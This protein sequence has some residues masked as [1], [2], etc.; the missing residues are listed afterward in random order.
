LLLV[1]A[2]QTA[3]LL[4]IDEIIIDKTSVR[5]M[6]KEE[7]LL[8][9]HNGDNSFL[10]FDEI[11]INRVSVFLSRYNVLD[12]IDE[13]NVTTKARNT[14]STFV[15]NVEII[16]GRTGL[17]YRCG[18][19]AQMRDR[20]PKRMTDPIFYT[21]DIKQDSIKLITKALGAMGST[22]ITLMNSDKGDVFMKMSSEQGEIL[23]HLI[24]DDLIISGECDKDTFISSLKLK[25]IMALIKEC[26][27]GDFLTVNITK[28]GALNVEVNGF[29][30]Y[31]MP[32]T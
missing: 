7:G 6:K 1:K 11:F 30:I 23:N 10:E 5:G 17:E 16:G 20:L 3:R 25:P 15:N 29:N 22:N 26:A 21:F 8:I 12:E 24:T 18:D 19:S 27:K 4:D 9:I 32:E 13:I 14:G 31:V 28:R 2:A